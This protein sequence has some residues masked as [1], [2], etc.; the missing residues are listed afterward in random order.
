MLTT[1][2]HREEGEGEGRGGRGGGEGEGERKRGEKEEGF[3][4]TLCHANPIHI[5]YTFF[6]IS[7]FRIDDFPTFG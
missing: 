6:P 7:P 3:R 2:T 4:G 1:C 5:R